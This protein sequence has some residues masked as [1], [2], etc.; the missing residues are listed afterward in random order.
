[1]TIFFK[2]TAHVGGLNSAD[3]KQIVKKTVAAVG[4]HIK[5]RP[6]LFKRIEP[7]RP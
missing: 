6:F 7:G 5:K 4:E 2:S 1:M 3:I